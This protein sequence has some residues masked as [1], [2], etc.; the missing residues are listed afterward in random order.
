MR[1]MW[2]RRWCMP[3][4]LRASGRLSGPS[5]SSRIL[6]ALALLALWTVGV[7]QVVL[8][9]NGPLITHLGEGADGADV[10]VVQVALGMNL[11]GWGGQLTETADNR[12]ADDFEVTTASGWQ[13]DK[14]VVFPY[15]T[16]SGLTSTI[17]AVNYRIWDGPPNDSESSVI[18]GDGTSDMMLDSQF[19]GAYR[20]TD[21]DLT[22]A[23]RPLMVTSADAIGVYLPPGTYW[24]DVQAAGSL[25][26]GPW[27]APVTI[28]GETVTGDALQFLSSG[29]TW[30]PAL[31]TALAT[32]QD[33]PFLVTGW[34]ALLDLVQED[35]P[36]PDV[37]SGD[38]NVPVLAFYADTV[39]APG[40][41]LTSIE[42]MTVAP[43]GMT[44]IAQ[45]PVANVK[46]FLD[47]NFDG[48][49]D[50]PGSPLAS[51][52]AA[53]DGTATLDLSGVIASQGAPVGF[54]LAYDLKSSLTSAAF[55]VV[56]ASLALLLPGWWLV[57]RGKRMAALLAFGLV[58]TL[59]SSCSP[60]PQPTDIEFRARIASGTSE[61]ASGDFVGSGV[62]VDT[63]G[64]VGGTLSV[65][66]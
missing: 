33:L 12:L 62:A 59:V 6:A 51:A 11:Y 60:A 10:S 42:V 5:F 20:T 37:S 8:H 17:T 24:F 31:D 3:T 23:Q 28:L 39:V 64:V 43:D 49:A 57:R 21:S 27:F 19:G 45:S 50:T 18:Y 54:V 35:I 38:T 47:A 22:N 2:S 7:S 4:T 52:A 53:A 1:T 29:G 65:R 56:A 58:V 15:Q 55:P 26:S 32:A 48:V 46:L 25:A 16:N 13:L 66:Y 9:D 36:V 44:P 34:D 41:E 14:F 40:L 61:V 63:T 30:G